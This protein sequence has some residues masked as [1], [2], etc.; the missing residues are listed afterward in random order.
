MPPERPRVVVAGVVALAAAAL[1]AGCGF[2]ADSAPVRREAPAPTLHGEAARA[3]GAVDRL[4]RSLRGGEVERL[5]RPGSVFTS[6]VLA[7]ISEPAGSCEASIEL[8]DALAYPPALTVTRLRQ[9][10]GLAMAR[11]RVGDGRTI[12]LDIV[13]SGRRWVVS[14]SDGVNPIGVVDQ[15]LG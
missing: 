3:A 11:V 10:G 15:A 12:P 2:A 14:F 5:C 4:E 8:S 7:Q 6:A 13:R 9:T 1:V